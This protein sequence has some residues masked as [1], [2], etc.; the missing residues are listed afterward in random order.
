MNDITKE[1]ITAYIRTLQALAE[2][3]QESRTIGVG[4]LYADCMDRM[5]AQAF[6]AAIDK[7][8]STGLVARNRDVLTWKGPINPT[9]FKPNEPQH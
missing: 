2:A 1:Q 7:L 4:L 9:E 8:V 5:S 6:N 3:V